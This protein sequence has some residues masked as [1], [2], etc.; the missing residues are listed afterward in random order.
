MQTHKVPPSPVILAGDDG[1]WDGLLAWLSG[2]LMRCGKICPEDLS[3]LSRADT[4]EEVVALL[5]R[6]SAG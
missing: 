6:S 1:F 4:A 2:S 3:L 5:A